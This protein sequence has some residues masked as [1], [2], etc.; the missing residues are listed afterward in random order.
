MQPA[1][2]FR[3]C[4]E[5]LLDYQVEEDHTN[6]MI[7]AQAGRKRTTVTHFLYGRQFKISSYIG[8]HDEKGVVVSR[9]EVVSQMLDKAAK[10]EQTLSIRAS[11]GRSG[12]FEYQPPLY[13][14]P[15]CGD[16]SAGCFE[17][18]PAK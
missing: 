18:P 12:I 9:E 14:C 4:L 3:V 1:E 2:Y 13:T 8:R 17:V 16:C 5:K 10:A 6:L 15:L 11:K 7:V